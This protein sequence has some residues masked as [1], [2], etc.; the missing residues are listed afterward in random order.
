M[1]ILILGLFIGSFMLKAERI[2]EKEV[3]EVENFDMTKLDRLHMQD[4]RIKRHLGLIH[5]R[6]EEHLRKKRMTRDSLDYDNIIE[7]MNKLYVGMEV[8][9]LNNDEP[10]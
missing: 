3:I 1:I 10:Q 4:Y 9:H 2:T 5:K 7:S 6:L 8:F